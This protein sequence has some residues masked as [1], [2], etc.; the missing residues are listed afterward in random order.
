MP[1]IDS[2]ETGSPCWFDLTTS[3]PE[4]ARAFYERLFGWTYDVSGPELGH[5]AMAKKDDRYAAGIGPQPPDAS[6]P[7]A[8]SVYFN[9]ADIEAT[10]ERVKAAGGKPAMPPMD[11]ADQGRISMAVDPTGAVFGLWQP[12]KHRGAQVVAEP[13]AMAWSEVA[14]RD[15]KK[16][17]DFYTRVFGL[18]A[19]KMEGMEYFTLHD[20]KGEPA[21]GVLQMNEQWPQ[22]IPPHWMPYFAVENTDE[23]TTMVKEFGGEVRVKPFDSPYGRIS[24]VSDPAGAV[25]SVVQMQQE[26]EKRP[27]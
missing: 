14:T 18:E 26:P 21:C 16:A 24:V 6:W 13:G 22:E 2:H 20:S 27:A 19:Q 23:S 9:V 25:F 15:A 12:K 4:R 8:W 1:L 5:Y 17:A 7:V 11:V 3:D 10:L